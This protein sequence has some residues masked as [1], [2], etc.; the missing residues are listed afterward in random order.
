MAHDDS[1]CEV[2]LMSG[3]PAAGKDYWIKEKLSDWPV[4]SLDEI[5]DELG[6][7]P[8][9]PQGPV[10]ARAR[11]IATEYLRNGER[12]VWNATSLSRNLRSHV[13]DLCA[14]YRAKIRIV[15]IEVSEAERVG[16]E[17]L[18]ARSV[19]DD[20]IRKMLRLWHPPDL[21]EAHSVDLVVGNR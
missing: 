14:N 20:A 1:R 9:K 16:R 17:R 13:I 21:T 3:L 19:P 6:I 15:Y 18:R 10:V 12:F 8:S 2:V 4:V 11:S 7:H 5:R